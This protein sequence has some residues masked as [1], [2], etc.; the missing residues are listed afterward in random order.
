MDEEEPVG[1]QEE[2]E[3]RHKGP[4]KPET[5]NETNEDENRNGTTDPEKSNGSENLQLTGRGVAEGYI[6]SLAA[7]EK[8]KE[9]ERG[10]RDPRRI[11]MLSERSW[12]VYMNILIM[13]HQPAPKS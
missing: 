11:V 1:S 9:E 12:Q 8:N 13:G 10:P 3:E 7:L 2:E 6:R 5:N 4:E